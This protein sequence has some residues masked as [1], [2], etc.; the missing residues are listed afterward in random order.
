MDHNKTT[1]LISACIS[2]DE[3]AIEQLIQQY[4]PGIFNL[5]LSILNDPFEATE[6]AQDTFIAALVGLKSYKDKAS[7]KSWLNKIALN[8]CR[9][10]LRKRKTLDRLELSLK[11]IFHL[12]SQTA[13]TPEDAVIHNEKR[14]I[15][16][17]ALARLGEKH[18][19]PIVL[20]Y[21]HDM[22]VSEIAEILEI[23]EGTVHS[24]LHIAR[25]RLRRELDS[26]AEKY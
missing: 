5:A 10:R 2:G 25:E 15:L 19:L 16:R 13:P 24:R 1:K 26:L 21:F 4:Q 14:A 7:F 9:S 18:R 3:F 8:I 23:N 20:R 6:A 12:Q 22:P 11:T 17:E